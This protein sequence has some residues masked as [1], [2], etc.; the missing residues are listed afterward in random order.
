MFRKYCKSKLHQVKITDVEL[1]YDGS[2]EIDEELIE[3]A[4]MSPWE[5]V[6]VVNLENGERFWTYIIPAERGSGVV[7]LKGPAARKAMVGDRV[8]VISYAIATE[9]EWA[10]RKPITIIVDEKNKIVGKH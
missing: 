10:D 2:I 3:A 6:Q 9:D 8:I 1:E 4:D 5:Q 7:A